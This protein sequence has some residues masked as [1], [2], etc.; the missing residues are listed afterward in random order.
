MHRNN[1][2]EDCSLHQSNLNDFTEGKTSLPDPEKQERRHSVA[3]AKWHLLQFFIKTVE[4]MRKNSILVDVIHARYLRM[5]PE[6][7]TKGILFVKTMPNGKKLAFKRWRCLK[8]LDAWKKCQ[9]YKCSALRYIEDPVCPYDAQEYES[10]DE[11][12]PYT[13]G[14]SE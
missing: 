12:V 7:E 4:S 10:T 1:K 2:T 9:D 6:I 13:P 5:W 11:N 3:R 14:Q 8:G